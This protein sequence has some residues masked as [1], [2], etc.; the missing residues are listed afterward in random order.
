MIRI[1]IERILIERIEHNITY[2]Y[3]QRMVSERRILKTSD[4]LS[5]KDRTL[6]DR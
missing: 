6:R 5:E 2:L 1:L 4:M 3:S